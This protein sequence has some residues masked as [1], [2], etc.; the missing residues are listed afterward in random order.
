MMPR[1]ALIKLFNLTYRKIPV[2]TIGHD[3]YCDTSIILE[4]LEQQFPA[5]AGYSSLYPRDATGRSN[6][7]LIRGFTSFWTDRPLFRVTTGLI[8]GAVWRTS[9]GQDR[10][11]LIGHKLDPDKLEKKLPENLSKLDLQLSLFEDLFREADDEWVFWTPEPSA[12]DIA[13]WYQLNWGMDIAAGKGVYDLTGG[14]TEDT[15]GKMGANDVFN[16]NRYPATWTWFERFKVHM[17]RLP[18]VE[19]KISED[20]AAKLLKSVPDVGPTLLPTPALPHTD[21]D[22][23]TGLVSGAVVSV[24]PD[25]T[26]RD[27]QVRGDL[28]YVPIM[29]MLCSPTIG[30]LLGITPEEVVLKPLARNQPKSAIDARIHFPRLGFVIRPVSEQKL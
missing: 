28:V 19:K 20:E 27:E 9:F 16:K 30:E 24:T 8:P 15:T 12:A 3:V 10:A 25:D 18:E 23:K 6:Q 2:L 22:E 5:S 13:I 4:A 17:E 14:G 26:G 21:L 7:A 11:K 29:L 1:P